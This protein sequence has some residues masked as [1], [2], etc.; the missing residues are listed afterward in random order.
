MVRF[1]LYCNTQFG[2]TLFIK[3]NNESLRMQYSINGIWSIDVDCNSSVSYSYYIK[4]GD[5]TIINDAQRGR[6]VPYHCDGLTIEDT[7]EYSG[8]AQ[9]FTTKPFVDVLMHS[10][11]NISL[12]KIGQTDFILLLFA[13]GI[14]SSQQIFIV[15]NCDILGN[16]DINKG[17]QLTEISESRWW[18][19]LPIDISLTYAEYKFVVKSGSNKSDLCWEKCE[20]RIMPVV[21]ENKLLTQLLDI[22]YDWHGNGV[23]IPIFSLRS[24]YDTGIGDFY[25]LKLL[26]NWSLKQ[27]IKVIQIL[28][29]NDTA[30]TRTDIDSYPYNIISIYALNPIY[31]NINSVGRLKNSDKMIFFN[32]EFNKLQLLD[33]IDYISVYNT[34]ID[35]LRCK[36]SEDF[37]DLINNED[38]IEFSNRNEWL[39]D[40]SVFSVLRDRYNTG[41]W[42]VWGNYSNYSECKVNDFYENHK[43]EVLFYYYI[44][45]I[46]SIQLTSAIDYIHSR[47]VVIKG[48]LPIG[49]NRNSVDVWVNPELFHLDMQ[50]G[51]PPDSFSKLGQNWGFP[52]YNWAVM[53]LSDFA[54]WRS[55]FCNL[56]K[57]FDV[58]RIDH[59]LG[60][61]RIWQVPSDALFGVLGYFSPSI[62][63]TIEEIEKYGISFDKSRFIEPYITREYVFELFLDNSNYIIDNYLQERVDGNL[64]FKE[65]YK[66]QKLLSQAKNSDD[67]LCKNESCYNKLLSLYCEVLFIKDYSKD[68]SYYP[69]INS[70]ETNSYRKL[71]DKIRL[72][73]SLIHDEFFYR[74][75][76]NLWNHEAMTILP[77]LVDTT[78]M[79]LCAE[80]LG[81][82]PS[83]VSPVLKRL[84]ILS[85]EVERMPKI[86][87]LDFV[88]VDNVPYLSV[89]TTGTHDM[90]TLRGWWTED[91]KTTKAYYNDVLHLEGDAPYNLSAEIVKRILYRY[92]C[93]SAIL[94]IIPFQDIMACS[95]KYISLTEQDERINNPI[96]QHHI[97]NWR[98]KFEIENIN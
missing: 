63:Y 19:K 36:Y 64:E 70:S 81:M 71:D 57:Y 47:G 89:V 4:N 83:C 21:F 32:S 34:K 75:N 77:K 18:I 90:S 51:A 69:R 3:I 13:P 62:S 98:M 1:I 52:T 44:Q 23:S 91:I 20:N 68:N 48:D 46:L 86:S 56:S 5:G 80:D 87:N 42:S 50:A 49:I 78:N 74:R 65:Q 16:W 2:Q 17:L 6:I 61:F 7:F 25:D 31:I 30:D 9:I 54:W 53:K 27:N 8:L 38:F 82:V 55:R 39:K 88:D 28:P 40:Y 10:T 58:L 73:V 24:S 67:F 76:I 94:R 43:K 60:F 14:Q 92:N 41:D 35:Y 22:D 29:I 26:C 33:R 85:L 84:N 93:S 95:D 37:N 12:P 96:N 79:L 11:N 15:G 59:I 66:T 72:A 45:F 97:W